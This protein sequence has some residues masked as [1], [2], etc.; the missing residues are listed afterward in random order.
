MDAW[1]L[2]PV[3]QEVLEHHEQHGAEHVYRGIFEQAKVD[4]LGGA[5]HTY[6]GQRQ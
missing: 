5:E 1:Q 2:S 6:G 4:P 3:N